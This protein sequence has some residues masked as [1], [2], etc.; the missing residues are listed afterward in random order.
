MHGQQN[1]KSWAIVRA[2]AA[3]NSDFYFLKANIR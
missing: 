3:A 2:D 1:I